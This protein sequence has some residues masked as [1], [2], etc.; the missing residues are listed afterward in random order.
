MC[1]AKLLR[2]N[3]S[4][5]IPLYFLYFIDCLLATVSWAQLNR[6]KHLLHRRVFVTVAVTIAATQTARALSNTTLHRC[7]CARPR[8]QPLVIAAMPMLFQ[9]ASPCALLVF[10]SVQVYSGKSA[11]NVR[12]CCRIL[13]NLLNHKQ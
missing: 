4:Q 12:K 9:R 3:F 10:S 7:G 1:N 2:H 8:V 11:T 6:A 5:Q 13:K